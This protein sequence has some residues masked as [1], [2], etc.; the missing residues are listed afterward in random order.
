LR[1]C[2]TCRGGGR[3]RS[4][5][6]WDGGG[7]QFCGNSITTDPRDNANKSAIAVIR[8]ECSRVRQ[9]SES[10][11]AHTRDGATLRFARF[12]NRMTRTASQ[13]TWCFNCLSRT[14]IGRHRV[15]TATTISLSRFCSLLVILDPN[16]SSMPM[17]QNSQ[18]T[19]AH[20][21]TFNDV[22]RDQINADQVNIGQIIHPNSVGAL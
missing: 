11:P 1:C 14:G 6:S 19:D 17:F 13:V 15:I 4:G 22:G 9:G 12:S 16:S 10:D 8:L 7:V 18:H 20:G 2:T 3:R 21:S 5:S